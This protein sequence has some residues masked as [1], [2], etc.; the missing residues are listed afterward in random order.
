MAFVTE[1]LTP[2][3]TGAAPAPMTARVVVGVAGPGRARRALTAV[4]DVEV[5][6]APTTDETGTDPV[7]VAEAANADGWEGPHTS[8]EATAKSSA[9]AR[10]PALRGVNQ[11]G[12]RLLVLA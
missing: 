11:S 2:G 9:L 5:A 6:E 3:V 10:T 7:V 12:A 4:V 8:V 1:A